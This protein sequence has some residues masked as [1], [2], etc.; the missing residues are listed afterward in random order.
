[1]T[2]IRPTLREVPRDRMPSPIE[3]DD[4]ARKGVVEGVKTALERLRGKGLL[5][6][7]KD[8]GRIVADPWALHEFIQVFKANRP[9]FDDLITDARAR[10]VA[11]DHA[12]LVCGPSLAQICQ[13]LVFT[14][15]KRSFT[16]VA[17]PKP[18]T[19]PEKPA[20]RLAALFGRKP[21]Q[22]VATD[23]DTKIAAL[24]P[25]LAFDWQLPLLKSYY[26][27]LDEQQIRL[28]G[29]DLLLLRKGEDIEAIGAF[30]AAKMA[31]ARRLV[32]DEFAAMLVIR[33]A[34]MAGLANAVPEL[35]ALFRPLLGDRIWDF[36][37]RDADYI[38]QL[39]E[40]DRDLLATF[41]PLLADTC[42]EAVAAFRRMPLGRIKVFLAAMDTVLREDAVPLL[43]DPSFC[44]Q[45][46]KGMVDGF[47]RFDGSMDEFQDL[48]TMKWKAIAPA[49]RVYLTK[50]A[51]PAAAD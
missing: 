38:D 2:E 27:F 37:M 1:M 47:L 3:L 26:F 45:T 46:L 17:T 10:P 32:G 42:L 24:K 14:C 21:A 25:L 34:A 50:R 19:Q 13:M 9:M 7:D 15:A 41:G 40:L 23:A 31:Q 48:A 5:A 16:A 11:D 44:R 51:K 12:P 33:P 20:G 6:A 39:G 22:P 35:Y 8:Y 29:R 36:M 18:P 28:L 43:G 4:K 49:A 30:P